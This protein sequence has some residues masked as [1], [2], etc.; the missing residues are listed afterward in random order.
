MLRKL[1]VYVLA[2]VVTALAPG[3]SPAAAP[4]AAAPSSP[5]PPA[6]SAD[7]IVA[8]ARGFTITRSQLDKEVA[9][10]KAQ[11]VASGRHVLNEETNR[12]SRQILEQLINVELLEAKATGA[13]KAAGKEKAQQRLVE[14]KA[15][16]GSEAAFERQLKQIGATQADLLAKWTEA[17]TADTVVKRDLN[18][19]ISDKDARKFYD[20]NQTQFNAPERLRAS[21]ILLGTHDPTSGAALSP[22][23]QAAKRKQADALLKRARAGEDFAKLAREYSDDPV[24]KDKGGVYTFAR[25][26]MPKEFEEAAFALKPGQI[27][28]IVIST[29]GY[30][31]IKLDEKIAAHKIKY[32]DATTDIKNG[33]T[34]DAIQRQFPEYIAKLR[35]EAGVEILDARL[36]PTEG[37][38]PESYL[39]PV[40]KN[41]PK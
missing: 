19:D 40:K 31:I 18:I 25:G 24:S 20:D 5:Q 16:A 1:S 13:D 15:K 17:L 2:L 7:E 21:H 41:A 6:P 39:R 23:Q 12:I 33:L 37:L 4:P 3:R 29:Y 38:D 26:E 10:A 30:H 28:D 9:R 14:A 32:A 22:D 35:K 36:Q 34:Q 8:K 27:S 11:I